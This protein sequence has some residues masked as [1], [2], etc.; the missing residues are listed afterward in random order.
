MTG[1]N[2]VYNR[3]PRYQT[4]NISWRLLAAK[5]TGMSLR[6]SHHVPA[7]RWHVRWHVASTAY[8]RRT[9]QSLCIIVLRATP[10]LTEAFTYLSLVTSLAQSWFDWPGNECGCSCSENG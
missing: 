9:P 2:K 8:S 3:S 7:H 5:N 6:V 10:L 4:H 1:G